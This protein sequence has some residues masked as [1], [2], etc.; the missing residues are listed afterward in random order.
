VGGVMLTS[1]RPQ[2]RQTPR[3][4]GTWPAKARILKVSTEDAPT[5]RLWLGSLIKRGAHSH[6]S[7]MRT[8]AR[9]AQPVCG[10]LLISPES[11]IRHTQVLVLNRRSPA[12]LRLQNIEGLSRPPESTSVAAG[13]IHQFEGWREWWFGF[14]QGEREG[15]LRLAI[16]LNI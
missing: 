16:A 5:S 4:F 12:R 10:E 8:R 13:K 2:I 3:A 6:A 7:A 11:A 14:W 9:L 15:D 1:S